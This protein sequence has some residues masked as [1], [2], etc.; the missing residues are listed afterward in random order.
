[1]LH[2]LECAG[3]TGNINNWFSSY[4]SNRLQR[5]VVKGE[6]S[7]WG[8]VTA[9]VPHGSVLGPI[10]F[11]IYI[12]DITKNLTLG[13]S[14]F[15]DDN[16]IYISSNNSAKNDEILSADLQYNGGVGKPVASNI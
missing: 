3:I 9:G 15:A 1:M 7:S 6:Y 5:V 8:T 2:K 12:N 4:L 14:L 11:L 16:M 13:I 10:L